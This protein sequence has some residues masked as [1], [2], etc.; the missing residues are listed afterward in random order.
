[1]HNGLCTAA[2]RRE[3]DIDMRDGPDGVRDGENR[4]DKEQE[5]QNEGEQG[6]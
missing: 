4:M 6:I 3:A 1:M 5:A 2:F